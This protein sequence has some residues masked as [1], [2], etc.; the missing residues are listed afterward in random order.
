MAQQRVIGSVDKALLALE[1]LGEAGAAGRALARLAAELGLN[2]GSLHHTLSSLRQHGFVEQDNNGNY[3]LGH[4]ILALAD[5]YLRD[6]SLR[7][8]IHDGLSTLCLRIN[9]ICHLGVL[10]GEDIVYID[11]IVPNGAINTWSTVGWR[12]PALT[13]ALGRAIISQKYV[14]FQSFCR[15]FPTPIIKRTART[16]STLKS[17]WQE[18]MDARERGFAR[19]EQEYVLGTSC[20]AVAILRGPKVIG[21]ISMTGPSE[22]M[23]GGRE[24]FL[25]RALH[26]SIGR[27]LP[28]GLTLQKPAK[29]SP[30]R[31]TA[32][33]KAPSRASR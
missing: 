27:H 31:A 30:R 5:T 23:D 19:E 32:Q 28:P 29:R 3:R 33:K 9:E 18:L 21:A 17:V 4:G 20:I 24:Q 2:K 6:E 13:T 15:Q 16:R 10:I 7:S 12:N 1:R 26:E 22:R 14:D 8:I 11:K 25:V